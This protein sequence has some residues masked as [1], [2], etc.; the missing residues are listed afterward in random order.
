MVYTNLQFRGDFPRTDNSDGNRAGQ[1]IALQ[2]RQGMA[3]RGLHVT[4]PVQ[5]D[6]GWCFYV[7]L[8]GWR[9]LVGCGAHPDDADG[10]LCF[11]DKPRISLRRLFVPFAPALEQVANV[12]HAIIADDLRSYQ[13]RWWT[14]EHGLAQPVEC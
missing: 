1:E 10:W 11:V 3:D 12:M 13:R 8:D 4:E 7:T 6:W 2:L 5:E 9:M 14:D